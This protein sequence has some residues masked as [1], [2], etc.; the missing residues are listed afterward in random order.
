MNEIEEKILLE[1]LA[2]SCDRI[3]SQVVSSPVPI[4]LEF[5]PC[6]GEVAFPACKSLPFK[7]IS[8]GD[9]WGERWEVGW[10]KC[11]VD[12]PE[13]H[14]GTPLVIRLDL[15]GEGLVFD[16][17][18][19]TLQGISPGSVFSSDF[20]R[21]L[22]H[23]DQ[24]SDD[25]RRFVLW[26]EASA[27]GLFG[28]YTEPDPGV[29]APNRYGQFEASVKT[30][31]ICR[32]DR[33]R[34]AFWI[35]LTTVAGMLK[36]LPQSTTRHARLIEAVFDSLNLFDKGAA[37]DECRER[38]TRELHKSAVES[39][40]TAVSVGHAHID[41]AWLWP[42]R[43]T[44]RKCARTFASQLRLIERYPDYVFGASQP[45]HYQ[46]VKD[47]YP[48]LYSE[49]S[50]AVRE[51]R[52]EPQ[53]GM[54]VEADCNLI[55]GESMIRQVLHGKNF[56]RDEFGI[57]VTNLW[58]PDVFGYSAAL[59]QILRKSGINYFLTQK[60]SWSQYNK[61]PHH[62]FRWHG[63]DGSEV[64]AHFPPEDTYN[65]SLRA[66]SLIR[67]AN[68]FREPG[69]VDR[70]MS[71]FGV[72]DGGGGPKEE[73]VELGLRCLDCEGVPKVK[74]GTAEKFFAGMEKVHDRLPQWTGELYLE[75][76]RGTLTTQASNKRW[77]RKLEYRLQA[78]ELLWSM[79]DLAHYPSE[80]L[81]TGWRSLMMNQFH[82]ILP[83]SSITSVYERSESEYEELDR[84][85][86]SLQQE[87]LEHI[88]SPDPEKALLFN[89]APHSFTGVVALPEDWPS[90]M[91]GDAEP[92]QC[93]QGSTTEALITVAPHQL[94]ELQR[95]RSSASAVSEDTGLI[96]ENDLVLYEFNERAQVI[97][98]YDKEADREMIL[99]ES[100]GNCL[101]LYEDRPNNWDAWDI[102]RTYEQ[103]PIE[104]QRCPEP[105]RRTVGVCS[106]SLIVKLQ[107]GF[108]RVRQK[109]SLNVNSKRLDFDT[110]IEWQE[111]HRMLRVA[112][113]V[114]I[115]A[116][117][118]SF[119]IQ[120]GYLRRPTHRNTSWDL[121]RFEVAAHR[122]VDLSEPDYGVAL[123]NDCKYG[124]K[125]HGNV[126]DL[127][128][129]RSPTYPDPDA[130][131]GVHRLVY[132]LLPH[133]GDL[134]RS[135]VIEQAS[136]LNNPPL[137]LAG[138]SAL[139]NVHIPLRIEGDG[140]V[141]TALKRA[142]KEDCLIARL[143]EIRGCRSRATIVL[144]TSVRRIV[145]CDLLEWNELREIESGNRIDLTLTPF[146]IKTFKLW[147]E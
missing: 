116:D 18:G 7:S 80:R 64:I 49:I 63:I 98:A 90:A 101:T 3:A 134:V 92:I 138:H 8:S 79:V 46:F 66:E 43:E 16:D 19:K 6:D 117:E 55:S 87:A 102:D 142:E 2:R 131:R 125:V 95:S 9:K 89:P 5:A 44:I 113:P 13:T 132:G 68:Q 28:V 112:F 67:G 15:G 109:I 139:K 128:L 60:M 111:S 74:F 84:E 73:H 147:R 51:G 82:D 85:T 72:G 29:D 137:M 45:Q 140:V 76:H 78:T 33:S 36:E 121:A 103:T 141:M 83:G 4:A 81:A 77:N 130:D 143:V 48:D 40:L 11:L 70:F 100:P 88:S 17:Q 47:H 146:E 41:T 133:C 129:L 20:C 22:I 91:R 93:Q 104:T 135:D 105:I 75:L 21:D 122:Y 96:L 53:G 52:W 107:I 58:L 69:I 37:V 115:R 27:C 59:P 120:Y 54:W 56:F 38:L 35:D 39:E 62:T 145:E 99:G 1:R 94:L 42:I 57:D 26:I 65:A 61:F 34:W 119:D 31:D 25:Q 24:L 23:L 118:A 123:L 126:L 136:T 86:T 106:Q 97:R 14:Q 71:L 127:C 124:H 50:R 108:S 32:F 10:F 114:E 12:V 144:E 110:T 30:A